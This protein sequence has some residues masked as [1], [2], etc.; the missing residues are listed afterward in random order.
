MLESGE[1]FL[2]KNLTAAKQRALFSSE[3]KYMIKSSHDLAKEILGEDSP[4]EEKKKLATEIVEAKIS[5]LEKKL[6]HL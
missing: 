3:T 6:E 2:I 5:I 4:K 1:A